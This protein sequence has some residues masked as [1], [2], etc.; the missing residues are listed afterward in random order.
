MFHA[1]PVQFPQSSFRES[2]CCWVPELTPSSILQSAM[3]PPLDHPPS[4]KVRF[5]FTCTR[6]NAVPCDTAQILVCWSCAGL[7]ERFS[8]ARQKFTVAFPFR[9][10]ALERTAPVMDTASGDFPSP[11]TCM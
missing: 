8:T 2:H 3:K 1:P 4:E 6:R 5:P 10:G 11:N 9:Q 7:T